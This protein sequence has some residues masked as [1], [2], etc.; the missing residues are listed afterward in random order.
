MTH[1]WTVNS[2]LPLIWPQIKDVAA[3]MP[4]LQAA[5]VHRSVVIDFERVED[6]QQRLATLSLASMIHPACSNVTENKLAHW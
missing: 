2:F 4:P 1:G 5:P 6:V 3:Q